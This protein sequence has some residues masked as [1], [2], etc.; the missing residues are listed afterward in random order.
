MKCLCGTEL[1]SSVNFTGM[2][3]SEVVLMCS[4][5]T[6]LY[7]E[8]LTYKGHLNEKKMVAGLEYEATEEDEDDYYEDD[9]DEDED[10]DEDDSNTCEY[11]GESL[12]Y[13]CG[14]ETELFD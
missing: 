7:D 12:S 4:K 3:S 5:C 2:V 8:E 9:Y 1:V 11:C 6:A 14:C 10:E 13:G